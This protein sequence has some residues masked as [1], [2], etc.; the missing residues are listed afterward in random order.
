M[1]DCAAVDA[2]WGVYNFKAVL[3]YKGT[4]YRGWQIQ[5]GKTLVPT[6]QQKVEKAL[7]AVK[8]EDRR[9]LRI[10]GAGRTDAGVHARG[11]V[12]DLMSVADMWGHQYC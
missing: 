9:V 11:Q 2:G 8:K 10:Q 3:A 12:C 7:T 6:V 5:N 1:S 4:A